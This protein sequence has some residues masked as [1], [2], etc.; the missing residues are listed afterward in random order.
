MNIIDIKNLTK[1][2][3]KARGI[4]NLNL[5]IAE[6]DFYG[7]IGPNGAG[8]STTIRTL[9][10]L[11]APTSGSATIMGHDIVK[12][13][14]LILNETGYLPSEINFYGHM[15]VK[16]AIKFSADL[17][18]KKCSEKALILCER[19]GLDTSKKVDELSLGNRKKVG[20]VCAIQHSPKLLILDEPT[21]GLDPLMQHEF[22]NILKEENDNGTTV[23]FSSH[24]LS[25]VQNYCKKA[26]FIKDGEIIMSDE[27]ENLSETGTKKIT[28]KGHKSS[29][30]KV[31][32]EELKAYISQMNFVNSSTETSLTFLYNGEISLLLNKLSTLKLSDLTITEPSLEEI[33]MEYYE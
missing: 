4:C 9:L 15:K 10:G 18:R 33:F 19:L 27:V 23:F 12:D 1:S 3:G 24:V 21:S 17:R 13:N 29:I 7:F 20:I 6:G 22:F 30:E 32:N 16:D 26:A 5:Q 8:K 11:I 31:L 28:L 25:E 2:Y 14:K